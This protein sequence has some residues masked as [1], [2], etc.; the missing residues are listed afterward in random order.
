MTDH[1]EEDL[2]N[3]GSKHFNRLNSS[4]ILSCSAEAKKKGNEQKRND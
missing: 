4:T 2:E 1:Q 3:V